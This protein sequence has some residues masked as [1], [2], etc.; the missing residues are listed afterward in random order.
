MT[1]AILIFHSPLF[2]LIENWAMTLRHITQRQ[3][4]LF[5]D[6]HSKFER[7]YAAAGASG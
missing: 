6:E 3:R 1:L 7:A 5:Y 4:E 2:M